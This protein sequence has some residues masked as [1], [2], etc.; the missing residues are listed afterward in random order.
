MVG[1]HQTALTA[2]AAAVLLLVVASPS[3]AARVSVDVGDEPDEDVL[4][5]G[6]GKDSLD[7]GGNP[8]R[9]EPPGRDRLY[10]GFGHDFLSDNDFTRHVG[11]DT[12]VGGAG[13]DSV[14]SYIL[15]TKAVFVDLNRAG[16]DG[17]RRERDSLSRVE[18]VL[19]GPGT[20]G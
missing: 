19:A 18:N 6:R 16:R 11:P 13:T 3:F 14:S 9:R 7:G 8:F 5:G 10:G 12:I 15:R 1:G 17:Q 4:E 2:V 20:T